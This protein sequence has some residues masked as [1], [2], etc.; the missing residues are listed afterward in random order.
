MS[1]LNVQVGIKDVCLSVPCIVTDGGIEKMIH[2]PLDPEEKVLLHR[3]YTVIKKAINS[4]S[5]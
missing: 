4:L 2:S 3:S 5:V 1:L